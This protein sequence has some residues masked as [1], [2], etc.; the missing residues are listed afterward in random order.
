MMQVK[1]LK[2]TV[3]EAK[4]EHIGLTVRMVARSKALKPEQRQKTRRYVKATEPPPPAKAL[5]ESLLAGWLLE[6][7]SSSSSAARVP[8]S[9]EGLQRGVAE[10]DPS[11]VRGGG[12]ASSSGG[13]QGDSA[14]IS[15]PGA[16][17]RAVG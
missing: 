10:C 14:S 5:A 4:Q 2:L 11:P 13:Q 3:E 1:R 17:G 16:D 6:Y 15:S 9:S 12:A 7:Q 8:T